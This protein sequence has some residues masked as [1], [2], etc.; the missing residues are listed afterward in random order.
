M[1]TELCTIHTEL[2]SLIR[3][4]TYLLSLFI[5]YLCVRAELLKM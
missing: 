3:L 4:Y 2:S 1:H 5:I